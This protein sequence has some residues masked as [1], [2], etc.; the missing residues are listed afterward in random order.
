MVVDGIQ[1]YPV[2]TGTQLAY[3]CCV[4]GDFAVTTTTF[5]EPI[6][7]EWLAS[8]GFS[9][10]EPI[11]ADLANL[12][13]AWSMSLVVG[14]G[15]MADTT[16]TTAGVVFESG[17]QGMLQVVRGSDNEIDTG[18]CLHFEAPAGSPQSVIKTL[19]LYA[20]HVVWTR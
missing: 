14:C 18:L 12:P 15:R 19:D 6:T 3:S 5:A 9:F 17:F 8:P 20:P 13:K 16:C 10:R 1:S 7:V 11:F 2:V 4:A